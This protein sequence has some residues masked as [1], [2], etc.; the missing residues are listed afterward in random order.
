MR[1]ED[2][3]AD[4]ERCGPKNRN[5]CR[6]ARSDWQIPTGWGN[7]VIGTTDTA[8]VT[9]G[10]APGTDSVAWLR[11][12][13]VSDGLVRDSVPIRHPNAFQVAF[14]APR[15]PIAL[16]GFAM[17][18]TSLRLLD[19]AGQITDSLPTFPSTLRPW[20]LPPGAIESLGSATRRLRARR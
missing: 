15:G 3:E 5:S 6:F 8:L 2:G 19:R 16:F 20:V 9:S 11:T 10:Y 4:K 12:V 7:G 13:T 14:P 18:G 1:R 17:D